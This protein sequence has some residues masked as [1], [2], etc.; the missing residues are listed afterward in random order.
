MWAIPDKEQRDAI[1][2]AQRR[3]VSEAY[4]AFLQR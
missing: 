4:R 2:H 1:R 3:V